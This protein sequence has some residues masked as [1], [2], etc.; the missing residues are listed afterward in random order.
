MRTTFTAHVQHL[1]FQQEF[2]S[3]LYTITELDDLG[4]GN[5]ACD[6]TRKFV[7]GSIGYIVLNFMNEKFVVDFS[8]SLPDCTIT[9]IV[10]SKRMY[11]STE[12]F[13]KAVQA[14]IHLWDSVHHNYTYIGDIQKQ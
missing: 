7:D 12:L 14:I 11:G 6:M 3:E 5:Y 9:Y 13:S 1:L 4:D 8:I 10:D 2:N